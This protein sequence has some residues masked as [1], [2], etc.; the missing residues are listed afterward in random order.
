MDWR[1]GA[2]SFQG[3][4]SQRVA[5]GEGFWDDLLSWWA[6]HLRER[7]SIPW[8][9]TQPDDA[10]LLGTDASDWGTGQL[11]W[12]DGTR[13]EVQLELT[14][15]EHRR[16]INWRELLGI[17]RCV[18]EFGPTFRAPTRPSV[19]RYVGF[20]LLPVHMWSTG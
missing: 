9:P 17:V 15:A 7:Y 13:E 12:L 5:L 6:V 11:A 14:R 1:R 8:V 20:L 16:P 19:R 4:T 10:V 2:V 18:E 3:G